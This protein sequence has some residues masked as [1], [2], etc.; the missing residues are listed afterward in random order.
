MTS[1]I[2]QHKSGVYYKHSGTHGHPQPGRILHLTPAEQA[3][4][5][6]LVTNHP[7]AGPLSLIVGVSTLHGPGKSVADI[8][9]VLANQDRTKSER[10][11][12]QSGKSSGG[13][14]F[15][16]E[17]AAFCEAHP[18]F[19]VHSHFGLVTVVT[20][21]SDLMAAQL[22][23]DYLLEGDPVNGIVSDAAHG[24]WRERNHLLIVSSVYSPLL[25]CWVP[26]IMSF[27]NGAS[28]EHYKYHFYALF[29]S[30]A[31]QALRKGVGL[32]RHHFSG[33]SYPS[34][35]L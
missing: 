10:R 18:R 8:S 15:I 22:V 14:R 7:N 17:F 12:I 30:I 25:Q 28:A 31:R 19:I 26:S 34:H 20:M 9:P 29:E 6:Q 4:F 13:D 11:A 33:V 1:L 2:Y 21:Q 16:T 3:E 24:F 32:E 23:K 35:L 5:R 27:S